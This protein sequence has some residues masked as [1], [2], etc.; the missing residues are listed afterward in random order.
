MPDDQHT[1]TDAGRT[2]DALERIAASLER[3]EQRADTEA[4]PALIS[5]ARDGGTLASAA[6]AMAGGGHAPSADPA[7]LTDGQRAARRSAGG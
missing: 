5:I 3:I 7:A 2:A 1:P 6:D 4:S